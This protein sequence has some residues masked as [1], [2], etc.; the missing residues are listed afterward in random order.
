MYAQSKNE[1]KS[2]VQQTLDEIRSL[3][4]IDEELA[5]V[6]QEEKKESNKGGINESLIEEKVKA[7]GIKGQDQ[8][9]ELV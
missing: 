2:S 9:S 1:E 4:I 7:S 8:I 3:K 6:K 5:R